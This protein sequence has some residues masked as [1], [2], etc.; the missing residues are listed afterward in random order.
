MFCK[1]ELL[2]RNGMLVKLYLVFPLGSTCCIKFICVALTLMAISLCTWLLSFLSD[3]LWLLFCLIK[4]NLVFP[5]EIKFPF[6]LALS[7]VF[8]VCIVAG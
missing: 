7:L 2:L 8:V 5:I 4:R 6:I 1:L 3:C